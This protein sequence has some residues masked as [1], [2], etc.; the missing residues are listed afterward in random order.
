MQLKT[1][2]GQPGIIRAVCSGDPQQV[3]AAAGETATDQYQHFIR[4]NEEVAEVCLK[5]ILGRSSDPH[6]VKAHKDF[7]LSNPI[8]IHF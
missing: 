3:Q 6:V 5:K 4:E 1:A 7:I 8:K 2:W